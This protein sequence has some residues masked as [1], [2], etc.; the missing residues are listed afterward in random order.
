MIKHLQQRLKLKQRWISEADREVID[1]QSNIQIIFSLLRCNGN[2]NNEII[3]TFFLANKNIAN[4]L[5]TFVIVHNIV[6]SKSPK[7]QNSSRIDLKLV[8]DLSENQLTCNS[9]ALS[10]LCLYSAV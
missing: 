9:S 7:I 6:K 1:I 3:S 5:I 2:K 4:Y 10:C 8:L